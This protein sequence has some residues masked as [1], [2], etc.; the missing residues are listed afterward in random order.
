MVKKIRN[1]S[2]IIRCKNEEMW[3]GHAIQS[4]IEKVQPLEIIIIDN[5]SQDESIEIV[6]NFSQ[7]PKLNYDSNQNYAKIKILS[8]DKYTPGK[9]LNMGIKNAKGKYIVIISAHCE[10]TKINLKKSIKDLN[11]FIAIFGNQIP[12]WKGKKINKRY[13]WSHFKDVS[14]INMYS[15]LEKRYFFHNAI[16]FFKTSFLKKNLFDEYLTGKEDRYWINNQI[17]NKKSFLY[18]PTLEVKHHY[19]PNGKTWAGLA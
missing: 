18:D 9:A 1:I 3:I 6:K 2:V 5:N 10:L 8:L 11:K 16:A 15:D 19:T 4:V 12:V 13:I 7:D 17:K 14:V